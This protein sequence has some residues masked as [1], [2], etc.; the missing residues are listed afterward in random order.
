MAWGRSDWILGKSSTLRGWS[1]TGRSS[2]GKW[3]SP[4]D[5]WCSASSGVQE[6]EVYLLVAL[7]GAGLHDLRKSLPTHDILCFYVLYLIISEVLF[8]KTVTYISF[9]REGQ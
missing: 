9:V 5:C 7:S 3:S 8:A 2:P 4:Q 6:A 1:S